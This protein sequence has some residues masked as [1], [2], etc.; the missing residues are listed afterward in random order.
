MLAAVRRQTSAYEPRSDE[1]PARMLKRS[2]AN[3]ASAEPGKERA[4]FKAFPHASAQNGRTS[5]LMEVVM[6]P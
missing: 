3:A 2:H 1:A 5:S 6:K 4:N